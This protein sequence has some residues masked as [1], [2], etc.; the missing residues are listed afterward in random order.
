MQLSQRN[1][2]LVISLVLIS[3]ILM[4]LFSFGHVTAQDAT[5]TSVPLVIPTLTPTTEVLLTPTITNT[6]T[7]MAPSLARVEA[8]DKD[9]GAN[10]RSAP[11]LNAEILGTIFPDK[12]YY[13]IGRWELWL[14]IQFD[15][16]PTGLAWVYTGVVNVSGM[17]LEAIP[18]IDVSAVPSPN[19]ATGAAQQTAQYLT[20]TPG[21]P[22]TA[23]ALQASATGVFGPTNSVV[24]ANPNSNVPL[25]T[26]TFP[27]VIVEATLRP[28][29]ITT[30]AQG[31]IPPIV[32][33][34]VLGGIGLFGLL[35]AA[36]RR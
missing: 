1:M 4:V 23:T 27:A 2:V 17:E 19:L 29:N 8:I 7:A 18:L 11:N 31:G 24:V 12:F 10:I 33:I 20:A 6:P 25:P 3:I 28:K 32:P 16:S 22:Q 21:A 26:F 5:A 14:Q 35:I 13:V 34:I 15:K 9:T 30:T 36:L